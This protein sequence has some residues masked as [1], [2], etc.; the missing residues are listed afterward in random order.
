MEA[1]SS[2]IHTLRHALDILLPFTDPSTP[3]IQ[4]II[5]TIALCSALYIAPAILER[6][7]KR[8]AP[9]TATEPVYQPTEPEEED[10]PEDAADT[11]PPLRPQAIVEDGS[12]DDDLEFEPPPLAPTPPPPGINGAPDHAFRDNDAGVGPANQNQNHTQRQTQSRI[13]G[14]KKAKS[15]ARKDQRRAYHE[16]VRQRSEAQRAAEA[17]GA[18]EREE[19]LYEE[20]RRRAA[21]EEEIRM[22]EKEERDRK[23]EQE[24]LEAEAE[25]M[26][27]EKCLHAVKKRLKEN[28][29]VDLNEAARTAQRERE[30]VERL[31][32]VGGVVEGSREVRDGQCTI[33]TGQGWLVRIDTSVMKEAY[34]R[35]GEVGL[36]TKNGRV[37]MEDIGTCLEKVVKGK[38][39]T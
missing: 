24:R 20:K 30:W 7:T 10:V 6:R 37:S 35:A 9:P 25:R 32:R 26:T 1:L 38:A 29:V 31:L 21:A 22:K 33:F 34:M 4:D 12:S 17:E 15:L 27:R 11:I 36:K 2:I 8:L 13:V 28:G 39:K 5:H 3:L 16:F 14:A 19:A 18:E 23:K